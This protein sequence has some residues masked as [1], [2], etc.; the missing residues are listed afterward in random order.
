MDA[1]LDD[2]QQVIGEKNARGA[3]HVRCSEGQM[4]LMII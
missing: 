1:A 3:W 2:G 4:T